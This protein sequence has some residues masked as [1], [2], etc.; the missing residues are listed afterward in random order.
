M[1]IAIFKPAFA[2]WGTIARSVG[3]RHFGR[4]H[5]RRLPTSLDDPRHGQERDDRL[6]GADIAL[7]QPEHPLVRPEI[8]TDFSTAPLRLC[9]RKR[10]RRLY[11]GRHA[12]SPRFARPL[13]RRMRARM[14][15]RELAREH[16]S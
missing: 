10:E 9:Q 15:K 8:G 12:P 6:A 14:S 11:F 13:R 16:S 7:Q 4:R 3:G 1:I 5:H 2:A